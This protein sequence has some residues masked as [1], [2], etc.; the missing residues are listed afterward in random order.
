M[1]HDFSQSSRQIIFFFSIRHATVITSEFCELLLVEKKY[2]RT[3][4][5][6]GQNFEPQ[7]TWNSNSVKTNYKLLLCQRNKRYLEDI[8]ASPSS[9]LF[10]VQRKA[11]NI[12]W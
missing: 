1:K 9:P 11:S 3:I 12:V 5:E 2:F 10:G 4:W 6:V 7:L 8:L